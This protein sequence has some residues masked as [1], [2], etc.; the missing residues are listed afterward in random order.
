[1]LLPVF[2]FPSTLR[3]NQNFGCLLSRGNEWLSAFAISNPGCERSIRSDRGMMGR[4]S[5]V[6]AP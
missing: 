5:E 6:F 1:M 2:S 4:L 3:Q